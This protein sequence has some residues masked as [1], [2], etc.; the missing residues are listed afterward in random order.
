M[1]QNEKYVPE[2]ASLESCEVS[3]RLECVSKDRRRWSLIQTQLSLRSFYFVN[4]LSQCGISFNMVVPHRLPSWDENNSYWAVLRVRKAL[5][6]VCNHTHT[7]THTH[8]S[9]PQVYPACIAAQGHG[10]L[11]T[12]R[13]GDIGVW[14][15]W[16]P[17]GAWRQ[18]KLSVSRVERWYFYMVS[19]EL[20]GHMTRCKSFPCLSASLVLCCFTTCG[21]VEFLKRDS[22]AVSLSRACEC[23]FKRSRWRR[24][25]KRKEEK[26]K[27]KK[28][29]EK[30]RK[31]K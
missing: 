14:G 21:F 10:R 1:H 8:P 2:S 20:V 31:V 11:G 18:R 6:T 28:R 22:L 23:F 24:E 7:H 13:L 9:P 29:N 27:G 17:L 15:V 19:L 5:R 26:S 3:L 16:G 12:P 4:I 30:K 25:E